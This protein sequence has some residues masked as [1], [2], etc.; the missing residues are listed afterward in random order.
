MSFAVD[1]RVV[2]PQHG[3]GRV[4]K[5]E[6]RRFGA[7]TAQL[8]Y[9]I[10]LAKGTIW[11]P[12]DH[13]ERGLRPLT[14]KDELG[15]YRGLLRSRPAPLAADHRQRQLEVSERLRAGTFRA[16]CEVVRDLSAHGWQK[17]LCQSSAILLRMAVDALDEE[18][19][20]ADGLSLSEATRQVQALL[21]ECKQAFQH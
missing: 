3:V 5:L 10:A 8:Y 11:V 20:A 6:S 19:A 13:H 21:L 16:R 1:D 4:V 15:R 12:V 2:H 18:W 7:G 17:P 14:S 9:E